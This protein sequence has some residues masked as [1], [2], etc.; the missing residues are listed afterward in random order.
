MGRPGGGGD[1][2]PALPPPL[3]TPIVYL[4]TGNITSLQFYAIFS[5]FRCRGGSFSRPQSLWKWIYV[6]AAAYLRELCVPVENTSSRFR[7]WSILTGCIQL[8][9]VDHTVKF[10]ILAVHSVE[11]STIFPARQ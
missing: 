5:G 10:R 2:P 4:H 9:I 8:L 7:L 1:A 3:A 6:A 11:Q